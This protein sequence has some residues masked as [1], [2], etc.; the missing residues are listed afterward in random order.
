M[1]SAL[2]TV[3]SVDSILYETRCVAV[4]NWLV[5]PCSVRLQG[6]KEQIFQDGAVCPFGRCL[7]TQPFL[8][9]AA[10]PELSVGRGAF[11][12][13]ASRAKAG[14]GLR[15]LVWDG[16]PN[17]GRGNKIRTNVR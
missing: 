12:N 17:P 4:I 7:S 14:V 2:F 15:G 9:A 3:S 8:G 5:P 6:S 13:T 10:W 11:H 16:L 1:A